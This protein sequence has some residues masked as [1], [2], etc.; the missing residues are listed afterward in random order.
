MGLVGIPGAGRQHSQRARLAGERTAR[1]KRSIVPGS[2]GRT[3]RRGSTG[4]TVAALLPKL[5]AGGVNGPH[6]R[7]LSPKQVDQGVNHRVGVTAACVRPATALSRR[8]AAAPGPGAWASCSTKRSVA[9]PRPRDPPGRRAGRAAAKPVG[10][11]KPALSPGGTVPRRTP[12]P[13]SLL[14]ARGLCPGRR[15]RAGRRPR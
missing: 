9:T 6:G 1:W 3:R 8:S 11:G 14:P 12:R 2:S 13:G 5:R 10:R 7:R 15:R 4:G